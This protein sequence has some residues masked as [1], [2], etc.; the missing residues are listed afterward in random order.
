MKDKWLY[1]NEAMTQKKINSCNKI[2]ELKKVN[3]YAKQYSS[4]EKEVKTCARVEEK[5]VE[6][7]G[8]Y[9]IIYRKLKGHDKLS[10]HFNSVD[11]L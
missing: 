3:F 8:K 11:K 2:V 7:I 1:I 5:R 9:F 10:E 4:G 6:I